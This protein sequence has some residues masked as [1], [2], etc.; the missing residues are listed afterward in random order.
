MGST[1]TLPF[2]RWTSS[3]V[4]DPNDLYLPNDSS[5]DSSR[6]LEWGTAM[7]LVSGGK[8]HVPLAA[9]V[10]KRLQDDPYFSKRLSKKYFSTNG[11]ASGFSITEALHHGICERVERHAF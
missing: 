4:V 9:L 11:L 7:D 3:D 10:R 6:A 5:Y 8:V 2:D 1:V